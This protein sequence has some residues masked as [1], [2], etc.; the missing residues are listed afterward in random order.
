MFFIQ[1]I[2]HLKLFKISY[3]FFKK[4][5][6]KVNETYKMKNYDRLV[7]VKSKQYFFI[8]SLTS[9]KA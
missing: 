6:Q 7:V 8:M 4:L 3:T 5:K 9:L 1:N 2:Q